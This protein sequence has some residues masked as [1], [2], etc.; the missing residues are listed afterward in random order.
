MSSTI[1]LRPPLICDTLPDGSDA[2]VHNGYEAEYGSDAL[3]FV[4]SK[5]ASSSS[6]C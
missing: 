4:N 1:F 2:N 6:K 3:S 5:L